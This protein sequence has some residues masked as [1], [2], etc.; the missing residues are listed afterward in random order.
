MVVEMGV[1]V[2]VMMMMMTLV[3]IGNDKLVVWLLA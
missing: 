1:G 2:I 3:M